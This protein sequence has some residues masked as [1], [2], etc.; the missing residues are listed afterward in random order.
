MLSST[1]GRDTLRQVNRRV[2]GEREFIESI[3]RI[4]TGATLPAPFGI[5]DD[6]ALIK[7]AGTGG[8]RHT[9]HLIST[10]ALIEMRHFLRSEPPYLLGRKSLAVNLSDIAAMGATPVSFLLTLGIPSDVT[11]RYLDDFLAGLASSAREH[12]VAL[13]GGDTSSSPG[14][15]VISITILGRTGSRA[16]ILT[17]SGARPG[18]RLYVSGPLGGSSAGRALLSAGFR[19][20]LDPTRRT[21]KGVAR[22][23]RAPHI[24]PVRL[25]EALRLHFEPSPRLELGSKL[26]GEGI[27]S[28]AIDLSDG[29][30]LDL[31]RLAAASG[32]GAR[33]LT[34]A[35]PIA[36][37]ARAISS[38]F[39]IDP[40]RHAL[41]GGEDYELL[42]TVPPGKEPLLAGKPVFFIG[43]VVRRRAGLTLEDGMGRRRTLRPGGFDHFATT[44]RFR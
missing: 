30:S 40:L 24:A 14:P 26:S 4:F 41:N 23:S 5:G 3:Q 19:P 6:A 44:P 12:G 20:R 38:A 7:T 2:T 18:D 37:C 21:L 1:S 8:T 11:K 25:L 17:R 10:D 34:P 27:A 9:R 42:F 39:K 22:P 31:A 15:F 16:R 35:I 13:V 28:S 32:V 33:L 43:H 29:L 36:D